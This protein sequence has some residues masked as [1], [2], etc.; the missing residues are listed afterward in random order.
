M[1][2]ASDYPSSRDCEG[3]AANAIPVVGPQAVSSLVPRN[4]LGRRGEASNI[5]EEI[6]MCC[7]TTERPEYCGLVADGV[8]LLKLVTSPFVSLGR[9]QNG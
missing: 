3:R 7:S 2:P 4:D 9:W 5:P 6:K 1:I 8:S